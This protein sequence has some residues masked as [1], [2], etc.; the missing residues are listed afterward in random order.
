MALRIVESGVSDLID[1]DCLPPFVTRPNA[2]VSSRGERMRAHSLLDCDVRRLC[3]GDRVGPSFDDAIGPQQEDCAVGIPVSTGLPEFAEAGALIAGR[4]VGSNGGSRA[5]Q[6]LHG[7]RVQMCHL[8]ETLLL[9]RH[10]DE[11]PFGQLRRCHRRGS[12]FACMQ[13]TMMM[14]SP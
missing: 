11:A 6:A 13:A 14:A 5:D 9:R 8:W 4:L 3:C 10:R 7:G 12:R 2:A 1:T